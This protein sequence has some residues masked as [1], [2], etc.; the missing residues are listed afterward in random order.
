MEN[1]HQGHHK[2]IVHKALAFL[3]ITLSLLALSLL[4]NSLKYQKFIGGDSLSTISVSGKGEI[5]APADVAT[6]SFSIVEEAKTVKVAQDVSSK[7]MSA[8]LDFLDKSQVNKKDIKT[9][10]YN[11]YPKYDYKRYS[12]GAGSVCPPTKKVLRGYEVSQS[13]DVKIR[14]LD[15]VG[16]I[17][18]GVAELGATNLGSLQFIIEDEEGLKA[19]ARKLA[20]DNAK[21]KAKK[22]AE[23]LDAK[24]I[25]VVSFSESEGYT[26][27]PYYKTA[28][29]ESAVYGA[30]SASSPEIPAGENK[31]S[32]NVNITYEIR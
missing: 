29:L 26:A 15:S 12:C 31:I 28:V 24:V 17:F 9:G 32:S 10:S 14:D 6:F 3:L 8:I 18:A 20:I 23:D 30:D 16:K 2:E 21:Q 4:A 7:K 25:R 19:Q 1:T 22:L 5:N 27:Y 13:V 11:F